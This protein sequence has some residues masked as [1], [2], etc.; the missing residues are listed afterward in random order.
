MDDK[1]I[2]LMLREENAALKKEIEYNK[3][4]H[5]GELNE[6]RNRTSHIAEN[7]KRSF[8]EEFM[9]AKISDDRTSNIHELKECVAHLEIISDEKWWKK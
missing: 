8:Q 4:G 5:R 9:W 7:I 3:N 1:L 6:L 2:V